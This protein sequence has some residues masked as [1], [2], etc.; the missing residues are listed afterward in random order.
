MSYVVGPNFFIFSLLIII[1]IN[2]IMGRLWQRNMTNTNVL[3]KRR[4]H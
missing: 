2:D 1:V 4:Q 3:Y